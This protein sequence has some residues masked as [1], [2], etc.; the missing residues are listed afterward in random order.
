ML[1]ARRDSPAEDSDFSVNPAPD[2]AVAAATGERK[3]TL[4]TNRYPDGRGLVDPLAG[5]IERAGFSR[6]LRRGRFS[7]IRH[8]SPSGRQRGHN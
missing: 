5:G 6:M 1:P 2:S 7:G 8:I 3:P 4:S